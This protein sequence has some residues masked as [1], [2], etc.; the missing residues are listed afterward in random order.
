MLTTVSLHAVAAELTR[1]E[2]TPDNIEGFLVATFVD[3]E[4]DC[5]T[6]VLPRFRAIAMAQAILAEATGQ[7]PPSPVEAVPA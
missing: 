7:P 5:A 1:T 6:I 4:G 3:A 2:P